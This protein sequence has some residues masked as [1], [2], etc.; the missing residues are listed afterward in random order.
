[1]D[2]C[3]VGSQ[4]ISLIFVVFTSRE[5]LKTPFLLHDPRPQGKVSILNLGISS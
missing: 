1:M 2:R 3:L 4:K 5:V